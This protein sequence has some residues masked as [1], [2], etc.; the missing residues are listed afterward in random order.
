[1]LTLDAMLR[2]GDAPLAI[3]VAVTFA[4]TFAMC[5]GLAQ[6]VAQPDNPRNVGKGAA[7][8][9]LGAAGTASLAADA[10]DALPA[11][12]W[13]CIAGAFATA[14][15]TLPFGSGIRRRAGF[16]L[17]IAA[18]ATFIAGA[19][20]YLAWLGSIGGG[21]SATALLIDAAPL[22][23]PAGAPVD[24]RL[25]APVAPIIV[26]AI[27]GFAG[28]RADAF[29]TLGGAAAALTALGAGPIMAV[30]SFAAATAWALGASRP[31]VAF[32]VIAL[33][34]TAGAIL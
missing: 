27:A 22:I 4:S 6:A 21:A 16:A 1:M 5:F 19:A 13:I 9:A 31:A 20:A 18:P 17:T 15:L 34:S 7:A 24:I 32:C 14:A 25:L 11:A 28:R 30:A 33:A 3:A 8:V 10:R 12:Y 26:A 2:A 29:A 23:A